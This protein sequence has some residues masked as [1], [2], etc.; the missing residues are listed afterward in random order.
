[1]AF[2][3]FNDAT[4]FNNKGARSLPDQPTIS[5]DA[6]KRKFDED[7]RDVV[8]PKVNVIVGE[9]EDPT[10]SASLGA[11]APTG[12]SGTTV[13]AVL[14][15]IASGVGTAVADAHTHSNKM[16][17]DTYTQTNTDLA[18][19]VSSKH[20]HSNKSL[21]DTYT[22]TETDL[23]DAVSKKHAH[24]NKAVLDKFSEVSGDPYYDGNPI[25]GGGGGTW[26]SITGDIDDQSDLKNAL[27]G[28]ADTTD[29][30]TDVSD[31]NNDLGFQTASDVSTAVATK[32]TVSWNQITGASGNT[33]IATITIDSTPTDIYAPSSGGG[34][35]ATSFAGLDDVSLS[36]T[37]SAGQIVQYTTV[38]S[39]V[40]LR[41]VN[42]P[43]IPTKVSDLSN[44]SGFQMSRRIHPYAY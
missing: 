12:F 4:D 10:A 5:A 43:T 30:P 22:Q 21:L 44:D 36:G 17:L 16:L 13:Q 14:N 1:M 19:A 41:N 31:L 6:L 7:A 8:A 42:M 34:G 26:G 24:S 25:G 23:A 3:R 2:T 32:S 28:K 33:K 18:D 11:V 40:K 27:D 38:G 9:L 15:S 37:P 29:I 20:T 39:D 35:G